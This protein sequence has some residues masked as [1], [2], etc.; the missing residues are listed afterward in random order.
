MQRRNL[1]AWLC[2]FTWLCALTAPA[3]IIAQ[4][5]LVRNSRMC[6]E[7]GVLVKIQDDQRLMIEDVR[8][9]MQVWSRD[10]V[11]GKEALKR[12]AQTFTT[13][14]TELYRLTYDVRGPPERTGSERTGSGCN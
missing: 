2:L 13:H 6:F 7:A 10:E 1:S 9:D 8:D 12:V 5:L 11:T 3:V 14:P 4:E